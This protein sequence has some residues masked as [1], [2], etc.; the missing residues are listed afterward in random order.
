MMFKVEIESKLV[1]YMRE[2]LDGM[3]R[4]EAFDAKLPLFLRRYELYRG[5]T[6]G[7]ELLFALVA[8]D[9]QSP[10]EYA[11]AALRLRS[12]LGLPVVFVFDRL[13][14]AKR[15]ALIRH[16]VA[17]VVPMLQMFLPPYLDLHE[18][19]VQVPEGRPVMRPASQSL[20]IRQLAMGDIEGL[21]A[22]EAARVL[23]CT[24]MTIS[25][26]VSEVSELGL[27]EVGGW[28]RR[29]HFKVQGRKLWEKALHRFRSPVQKVLPN[30]KPSCDFCVAGMT[31]LSALTMI[32]P[33]PLTVYA[34]SA[35]D[36]KA[37]GVYEKPRYEDEARS[38]LQVWLYDPKICGDEYVDRFSLYL[39]LREDDDP[40]VMSAAEELLEEVKWL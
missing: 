12:E 21:T 37:E 4:I 36:L 14:T 3:F 35:D 32:A 33:D 17:F 13:A 24:Q 20:V 23:H 30:A 38:L 40:R 34:C 8:K 5:K 28:P 22:K 26:V 7:Q 2:V 18:R 39:S 27:C 19:G 10:T 15:N 25:N 16:M 29:I 6:L 11:K 31:A 1:Q 9:E